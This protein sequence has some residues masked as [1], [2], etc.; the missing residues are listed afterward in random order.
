MEWFEKT[1][2]KVTEIKLDVNET[3]A[4]INMRVIAMTEALVAYNS[5]YQVFLKEANLR[6]PV[7]REISQASTTRL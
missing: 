4:M 3:Q 1:L 2:P 7:I 5:R 6:V